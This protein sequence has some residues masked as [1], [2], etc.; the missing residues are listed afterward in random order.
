[1]VTDNFVWTRALLS[2]IEIPDQPFYIINDSDGN[3]FAPV[4]H[5]QLMALEHRSVNAHPE[6]H[7]Q[8]IRQIPLK[9]SPLL[10]FL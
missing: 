10:W 7:I 1:M 4:T 8:F 9:P 6:R 5:H 2:F 3:R